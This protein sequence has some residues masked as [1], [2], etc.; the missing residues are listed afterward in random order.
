LWEVWVWNW[1]KKKEKKIHCQ[2]QK[3][4]C[5]CN[6]I[7]FWTCEFAPR[8]GPFL[9]IWKL[10]HIGIHQLMMK[11]KRLFKFGWTEKKNEK[12][13]NCVEIQLSTTFMHSPFVCR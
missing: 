13:R 3:F 7:H 4:Q 6:K 2:I 8:Q 11:F 10:Y 12:V 1:P 5:R 9:H